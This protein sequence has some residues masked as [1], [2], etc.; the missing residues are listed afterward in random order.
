[1]LVRLSRD[2]TSSPQVIDRQSVGIGRIAGSV[3]SPPIE[4]QENRSLPSQVGA[5]E[6]LRV[7]DREV[8]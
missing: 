6:D 8:R 3:A 4:G 5:E 1:M 2:S 7:V